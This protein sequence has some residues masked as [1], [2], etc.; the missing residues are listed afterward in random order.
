[1]PQF[2]S[3]NQIALDGITQFSFRIVADLHGFIL[4]A[5]ISSII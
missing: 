5:T 2:G 1:M 4:D 3:D